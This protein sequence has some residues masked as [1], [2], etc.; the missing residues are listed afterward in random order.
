MITP[1]QTTFHRVQTD[2]PSTLT[3]FLSVDGTLVDGTPISGPWQGINVTLTAEEMAMAQAIVARARQ[4]LAD[5]I[6]GNTP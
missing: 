5:Q 6:N 4:T 2:D 1:E 3:V